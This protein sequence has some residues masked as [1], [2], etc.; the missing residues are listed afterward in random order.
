MSKA[1]EGQAL[2]II[3]L[4]CLNISRLRAEQEKPRD[5]V[6]LGTIELKRKHPGHSNT[7]DHNSSYTR[8]AKIGFRFLRTQSSLSTLVR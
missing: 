4:T 3:H 1:F 2:T 6:L 5:I 8:L 7:V